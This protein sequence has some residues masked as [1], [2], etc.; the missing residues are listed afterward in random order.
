MYVSDH[1]E[2]LGENGVYLHGLPN[3]LAPDAQKHVATPL[4]FGDNCDEISVED[5]RKR[6]VRDFPMTIFFTRCS[7]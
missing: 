7:A 6:A 5:V 1:G 4:W 2:S 3:M